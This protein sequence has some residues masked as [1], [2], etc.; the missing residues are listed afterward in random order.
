MKLS[1]GYGGFRHLWTCAA[2][3]VAIA[4]AAATLSS[5]QAITFDP[6]KLKRAK[7]VGKLTWYGSIYP[8]TLRDRLVKD[9]EQRT[10]LDVNLYVGG[11]GQIVSRLKTEAK[12]VPATSTCSTEPTLRSST[13]S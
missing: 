3:F 4:V 10:G 5:A 1:F 13:M 2:I 7:K 11:T 12:L 6:E 8:E 9:F